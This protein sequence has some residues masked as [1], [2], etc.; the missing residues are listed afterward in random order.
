MATEEI[1][2]KYTLELGDLKTQVAQLEAQY[3]KLSDAEKKA[4]KEGEDAFNKTEEA[5]KDANK[6][7]DGFTSKLKSLGTA[8]VAAFAID[9]VIDFGRAS[10]AA[11]EEA[12]KSALQLKSAVSINGGVAADLERLLAQSDQLET[13]SIFSAEQ[14]QGLQTA[15][16]QFGLTADEVER[17]TPIVVDFA[18]ATGQDLNSAFAVIQAGTAGAAKGLRAYG[19]SLDEGATR[20]ENYIKITESLNEKFKGQAEVISNTTSGQLKQLGDAWGEIQEQVGAAIAPLVVGFSKL[21]TGTIDFRDASQKESVQLQQQYQDYRL[22]ALGATQLAVGTA[23]RTEQIKALQAQYPE[24]LGNLNAETVKNDELF[25]A[26]NKVNEQYVFKIAAAQAKEKLSPILEAEGKAAN[27]SS[28]ALNKVNEELLKLID[29]SENSSTA[30]QQSNID[31]IK[32]LKSIDAFSAANEILKGRIQLNGV[33]AVSTGN[34]QDAVTEYT[35]KEIEYSTATSEAATAL[36]EFDSTVANLKKTFKITDEAARTSTQSQINYRKL[37]N[38]ELK[39]LVEKTGDTLAEAEL[40][41]REEANK[42]NEEERKKAL[43]ELVKFADEVTRVEKQSAAKSEAAKLEVQRES[44]LTKAKELYILAGEQNKKATEEYNRAVAGINA[45]YDEQIKQAKLKVVQETYDKQKAISEENA[46]TEFETTI[47]N[48]ELAEE[49]KILELRKAYIA[50]GEFT[51]EE[52]QKLQNEITKIQLDAELKRIET[53]KQLREKAIEDEQKAEVLNAFSKALIENDGNVLRALSSKTYI[54][55]V[56]K[57]EKE[58]NKEKTASDAQYAKDKV[59]YE[60]QATDVAINLT[61][62]ETDNYIEKNAEKIQAAAAVA[63]QLIELTNAI[64][65]AQIA[66]KQNELEQLNEQSNIEEQQNQERFDRRLI[67]AAEFEVQQQKI[68]EQRIAGEKKINDE[69]NKLKRQQDVTNRA[70]S[71]FEI[72]LN[73]ALG[74]SRLLGQPGAAFLIPATIALGLAQLATVF[75]TPLPKYAKGTK[76]LKRGS[77]PAGVDT[78]PIMADEGERIVSAKQNKKYWSIYEAID[79]GKFDDYMYD[80]YISPHLENQAREYKV[81]Q[82]QSIAN[83]IVSKLILDEDSLAKKIG[84]ELEWRNRKGY[85]IVGMDELIEAVD[86]KPDPRKQ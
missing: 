39:A 51:K 10:L 31:N 78:I 34:L 42:K 62:Q 55:A 6:A 26:L 24:L 57:A 54:D 84:A 38:S 74:V 48:I 82:N 21:I 69:L 2:A 44:A 50:K 60:K 68:K 3:K 23:E 14:V 81:K 30:L 64:F 59:G 52:E 65:E 12:E 11:F 79:D 18:S 80:R 63:T 13:K 41:R 46:K 83:G 77:N 5:A 28:L 29:Q 35:E 66:A 40:Q 7:T 16:L 33:A 56:T 15:A 47:N 9:K 49:Q 53:S 67:G 37:L 73:T 75:A 70:R 43:S 71:I 36:K 45:T 8:I 19:V 76:F 1:I 32:F 72:T 58:A 4:G 61:T 85:K 27:A 20:Q 17:L 86:K 25:E 22:A